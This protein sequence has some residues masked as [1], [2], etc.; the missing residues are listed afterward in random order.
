MLIKFYGKD[1]HYTDNIFREKCKFALICCKTVVGT[2]KDLARKQG[3]LCL[4]IQ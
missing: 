1:Y 4:V 3:L 2:K